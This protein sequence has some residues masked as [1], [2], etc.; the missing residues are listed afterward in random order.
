MKRLLLILLFPFYLQSQVVYD[1]GIVYDGGVVYSSSDGVILKNL[2][3]VLANSDEILYIDTA[4]SVI[5][6]VLSDGNTVKW[7]D[8][9]E[10]VTYDGSNFVSV[11]DNKTGI[12][13]IIPGALLQADGAAQ[14]IINANGI[15]F[16]GIADFMKCVDFSF[17]Q[18]EQIYIVFKQIT[19]TG[20]DGIFDGSGTSGLVFQ[21]STTPGL[22]AN[23]GATSAQNSNLPLDTYGI[24]RVLFNSAS[25]ELIIDET[26]PI[27]G[28]FVNIDLNGF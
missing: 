19:W 11:W 2:T 15:L 18:P 14:P 25:S 6:A 3:D 4:T 24:M 20:N 17:I 13:G 7:F 10:N 16:D 12:T 22:E 9:A 21:F 8:F 5:P 23:S 1:G 28:D 26:T 27:T